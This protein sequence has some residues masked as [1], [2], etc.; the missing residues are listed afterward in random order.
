M[1]N[2]IYSKERKITIQQ[3][4]RERESGGCTYVVVNE[5]RWLKTYNEIC[6]NI[7]AWVNESRMFPSLIPP[8]L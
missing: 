7:C 4:E 1:H 8:E 2:L 5:L 6:E 3:A